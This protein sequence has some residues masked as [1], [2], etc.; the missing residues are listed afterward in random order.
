[1]D[2]PNPDSP[3]FHRSRKGERKSLD[4]TLDVTT[5]G[6]ADTTGTRILSLKTITVVITAEREDMMEMETQYM[7]MTLRY[8][9]PT[10]SICR[11]T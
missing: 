11:D 8:R 2:G 4:R 5:G 7:M 9:R 1:M 10:V 3:T 6:K